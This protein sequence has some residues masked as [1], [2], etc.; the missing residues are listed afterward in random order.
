[1]R[2]RAGNELFSTSA[3]DLLACGLGAVLVLWLLAFGNEGGAMEGEKALGGGEIRIRQF[4]VSHFIGFEIQGYSRRELILERAGRDFVPGKPNP[5]DFKQGEA[6]LDKQ[7][8]CTSL[9]EKWRFKAT[10]I[11]IGGES[12]IEVS[13]RASAEFAREV[14]IGFTDMRA[15][16]N[17]G[18]TIET[19]GAGEVHY[20]ET[21]TIDRRG[22]N[23][24]R[25]VFHCDEA[26]NLALD[27]VPPTPPVP[28]EK[29]WE[30]FFRAQIKREVERMC[31]PDTWEKPFNY[32][33]FDCATNI[34]LSMAVRFTGDGAVRFVPPD[35]NPDAPEVNTIMGTDI[36]SRIVRWSTGTY[37]KGRM[38][39]ALPCSP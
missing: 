21:Q 24:A 31:L 20:L 1:M 5:N 39:P 7:G 14:T 22:V 4:G 16:H 3:I 34:P 27:T 30:E 9:G 23:D 33:V 28:K 13:C 36:R 17:V 19:C 12:K 37:G 26:A 2:R 18:L 38:P 11:E 10:Y 32:M 25:Y 6:F 29:E 35:A 15:A 8:F